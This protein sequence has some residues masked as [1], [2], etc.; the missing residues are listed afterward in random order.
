[1]A[2]NL[3][4]TQEGLSLPDF[5][6][7]YGTE[8]QCHDALVASRWKAGFPAQNAGVQNI[9]TLRT[10]GCSSVTDATSRH[11]S[12]QARSIIAHRPP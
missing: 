6:E 11:L 2:I 4:Q 1:M 7:Q 9:A 3:V 12:Q 10:G 5:L 8:E